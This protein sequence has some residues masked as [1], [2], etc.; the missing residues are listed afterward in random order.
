MESL[1]GAAFCIAP[2]LFCVEGVYGKG[3]RVE[4][5]G[6]DLPLVYARAHSEMAMR[7]KDTI[8]F[9]IIIIIEIK[10]DAITFRHA[11]W[12]VKRVFLAQRKVKTKAKTRKERLGVCLYQN[13]MLLYSN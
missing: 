8:C 3:L 6:W 7:Q 4:T 12:I 1:E 13:S 2:M 9:V 10:C 5:D 11:F